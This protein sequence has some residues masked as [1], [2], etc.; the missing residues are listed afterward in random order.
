M[1]PPVPSRGFE[2]AHQFEALDPTKNFQWYGSRAYYKFG[3]RNSVVALASHS[4]GKSL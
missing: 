3:L 2:K 4:S 1:V